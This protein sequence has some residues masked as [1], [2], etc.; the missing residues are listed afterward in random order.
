[1]KRILI[2]ILLA[3]SFGFL[4]TAC[5][6]NSASELAENETYS[7]PMHP[8]ITKDEKGQCPICHMDLEKRKM[9]PAEIEKAHADHTQ[10]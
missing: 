5:N 2:I 8:Q 1:M 6:N 3:F 4:F 7:C 9:T 10:H